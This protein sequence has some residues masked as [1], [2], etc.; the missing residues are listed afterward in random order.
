[1][2]YIYKLRKNY[3]FTT[4]K[5]Y[6]I[7][8]DFDEFLYFVIT[9]SKNGN[10]IFLD[11]NSRPISWKKLLNADTLKGIYNAYEIKSKPI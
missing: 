6:K 10:A 9:E 7:L 8:F 5:I 4:G 11:E 2:I 1:M 3:S